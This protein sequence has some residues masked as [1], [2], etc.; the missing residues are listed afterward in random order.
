MV[1]SKPG[2]LPHLSAS[3][4]GVLEPDPRGPCVVFLHL[5]SPLPSAHPLPFSAL[6]VSGHLCPQLSA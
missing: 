5:A 3:W 4:S 2:L 1:S 6:L